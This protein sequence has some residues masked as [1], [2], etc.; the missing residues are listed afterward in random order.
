MKTDLA[1]NLLAHY[2]KTARP[3]PWRNLGS[4][5]YR[6]WVSE[7]MLQQTTVATVLSYYERFLERFPDLETLAAADVE[8]VLRLWQGLGYY[9]RAKNL[10]AAAKKMMTDHGGEF[11]TTIEAVNALPGVG[12]STAAAILAIGLEQP[13][14]ILDGNVKRVLSRLDAVEEPLVGSAMEK[15]LWRRAEELTPAENPG[16]YA[17]AIMDLG[18]T[19]CSPKNPDCPP[20]PWRVAC[21]AF[22]GGNP[23]AYPVKKG[24]AARKKRK[25]YQ[26]CGLILDD[27]GRVLL[28]KRPD[29]GVLAGLW[30]PPG[31][32]MREGRPFPA[33]TPAL[34]ERGLTPGDP[35]PLPLVTHVF[36]HF[37]LTVRPFLIRFSDGH[38]KIG[39]WVTK[40]EIG[41]VP[42]STLHRK[43]LARLPGWRSAIERRPPPPFQP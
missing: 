9:R 19:L 14:A 12:R 21:Q 39:R 13:H 32:E 6:I 3:L 37:H 23:E 29:E 34:E 35:L 5:L 2:R 22:A 40:G 33:L 17:Q 20:C 1:H 28:E 31:T 41:D 36:T 25:R 24:G 11:P 7:I 26:S 4:D 42:I 8:E 18:A 38:Q 27:R 15:K 30:A 10:H 16:D 43:I